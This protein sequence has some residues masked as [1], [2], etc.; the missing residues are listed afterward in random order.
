MEI[1]RLLKEKRNEILRIAAKYGAT[2]IR[3]FGSVARG[4]SDDSSDVDF[5][6]KFALGVTL[7]HQSALIRELEALL[8]GKVDVV[9]ENGLRPRIRER[10]MKEA[11]PL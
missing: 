3:I 5:L 2:N 1:T 9:S 4:E 11:I 6:V 8:G 10:I 7:I